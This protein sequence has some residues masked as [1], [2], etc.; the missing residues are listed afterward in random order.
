M[1]KKWTVSLTV[2][3]KFWS[4]GP[5]SL[6]SIFV[7]TGVTFVLRVCLYLPSF[8]CVSNFYDFKATINHQLH[9]LY[10]SVLSEG[11][12]MVQPVSFTFFLGTTQHC[13]NNMKIYCWSTLLH[14]TLRLVQDRFLP[15]PFQ[16][17]IHLSLHYWMLSIYYIYT[18]IKANVCLSVCMF[19]IN[20]LTP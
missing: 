15:H 13:W 2:S 17:I 11:H 12:L 7:E 1:C 3:C 5:C 4:T 20:S 18:R 10:V 14:G 8:R 19:K 6:Q 9:F 16:L